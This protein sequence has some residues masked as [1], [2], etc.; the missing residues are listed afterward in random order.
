MPGIGAAPLGVA[1]APRLSEEGIGYADAGRASQDGFEDS[2]SARVVA[3]AAVAGEDNGEEDGG[4][5]VELFRELYRRSEA[6]I[7]RLFGGEGGEEEEIGDG[8]GAVVM[9]AEMEDAVPEVATKRGGRAVDDDEDYDEYDDEEEEGD[10]RP[11]LTSKHSGNLLSP[12]KSGSSPAQQSDKSLSKQSDKEKESA[13]QTQP[14]TSE[15]ARKQLEADKKATEDAVKRSFNTLFYTLENDRVAMLEQQKLEESEKQIDA[16]MDHGNNSHG[17]TGPNGEHHGTLSSANL[18]AS[19]L[20]LKHLIARI[21][22]K[23]DQVRASDAELR[24]LMNEV[25][26]NR[27]KWAS[28]ENVGQEELYE[29]AEKVLSELK[30]MT[31]YSAP[32]LTRV[33]KRDAPDYNAIIKTPMDLGQMTKKLKTFLYKSKADFVSD[34]DLIWSNCLKYNADPSHPLRRNAN[35]MR[36]EAEKLVPLIPDIVV[37]PRAEVEAEERRKQ[38]GVEDDAGDESDDEPIMS[39]RGRKAPGKT[40]VKGSSKAR[41][42][43]PGR[44]ESTP[45][46]DQKPVLPLNSVIGNLIHEGSDF[47]VEGSQNGFGSPTLGGSNTPGGMPGTGSQADMMD[48]DGPSMNGMALGQALGAAAEDL[49]EDEEYRVW[50]QVTKKDRALA[51]KERHKL[52]KGDRL[53]PDEPALL[54]TKAGMRRWIRQHNV[55]EGG[56]AV[57]SKAA[58]GKEPVKGSETLAEGMEGGD[59]ERVLPDYYDPLSAI[60]DVPEKLQWIED[61]SGNL[62]ETSEFLR[63]IPAGHFRSPQSKLTERMESNMRQM[64]ETRK[65]CSKIGVVKQMQLQTQMY[66]NQF[67]KYNPQPFYEAD[68]EPYVQ[69]DEGPVMSKWVCQAALRRSVGKLCYH[70][71]FEELQPS[72]LDVI[73]DIAADYF[74]KIARTFAIYRE[75]PKV[76]ATGLAAQ[77]GAEWQ[78]RF[79]NEE[80]MLHTLSESGLD[81][82]TLESYAKDDNERFGTKLGVMHERMKAHLTDLLRP[83]LVDAGTDGVGAFNDGSEQF[84]GGDFADDIDEDFFG[85]KELGLDKEFGLASLSVPLH[86]LQAKVHSAHNANNPAAGPAAATLFETLPTLRPVTRENIQSQIGLVK[87]FFLAKLHA[88][89]D[90]PLVEDEDLPLKQRFPKP[91]LPPTGKITSPRKRPLKEQAGNAKKKKKLEGGVE[92][93]VNGAVGIAA[94][95]KTGGGS[96]EKGG[97]K[98]ILPGGV[99]MERVD[100]E[101]GE[102]G[103]K[104]EGG[105]VG[106]IS[107]ESIER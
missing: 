16:E 27:S 69:S 23:R 41:K 78:E 61:A 96:P 51:A 46:V 32:F 68:I 80:V 60:P 63:M 103:G 42:V 72:A 86:L 62:V 18:G 64:Q 67:Q 24:S 36:R 70:A 65:I 28:E 37:R 35:C 71:G 58:D 13:S 74:T 49:Q 45:G 84:V 91:R 93:L 82:E 2:Q 21:D 54:R 1:D 15:D 85:F 75:A 14:K 73:T 102:E 55:A 33:N 50:K 92:Q 25:R 83:A 26:K 95:G 12:S 107:P 66:N 105:A 11:Q 76:P 98:R 88:N 38:N 6:R 104:E 22:L 106:P 29:A 30:A 44:A 7:A 90:E 8:E 19:S 101:M 87:N 39:S 89:S 3:M 20:T 77:N 81:V 99:G 52:F 31:E 4:G 10:T 100:S 17:G 48:I 56:D 43:A 59:D 5:Q 9:D 97:K 34:L 79:T 40:G 47:G 94:V 57:D 53:N